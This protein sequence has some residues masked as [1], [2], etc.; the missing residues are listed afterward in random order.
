[1][2]KLAHKIERVGLIVNPDKAVCRSVVK[3]AARLI[4]NAGRET[5]TDEP[6]ARMA[7][8][9]TGVVRDAAALA[10]ESD[11]LLVFGG[12]GTMLRVAREVAGVDTRFWASTL[13]V[14][15]F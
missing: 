2:K 5:L 8:L 10:R 3:T 7:N 13:A 9:K 12:D 6:S 15:D 1:M 4:A 14:W 11:L